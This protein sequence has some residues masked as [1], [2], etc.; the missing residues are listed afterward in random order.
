MGVRL[1]AL[2]GKGADDMAGAASLANLVEYPVEDIEAPLIPEGE[3]GMKLIDHMTATQFGTAKLMLHFQIVDFGPQHGVKLKAFYNVERL[4]GK[5]GRRGRVKHKRTGDF[6]VEYFTALPG[7]PRP[8]RFDRIP[9]EP[10]YSA[11]IVG[12]VVTVKQNSKRELLPEQ[13]WYSKVGRMIR[14]ES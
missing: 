10:L 8:K 3:Y 9:M 12:K 13:L 14:S 11:H 6:L 7:Q 1:L 4:I 2:H 5:P